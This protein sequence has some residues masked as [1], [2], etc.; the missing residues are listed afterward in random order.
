MF[1]RTNWTHDFP[2]S[3]ILVLGLWAQASLPGYLSRSLWNQLT[4]PLWS[5]FL[6]LCSAF[7]IYECECFACMYVCI[8]WVQVH[9]RNLAMSIAHKSFLLLARTTAFKL[10]L[11]FTFCDSGDWN[12]GLI[13][14][15]IPM[16]TCAIL[17]CSPASAYFFVWQRDLSH[18]LNSLFAMAAGNLSGCSTGFFSLLFVCL[19]IRS[20][21]CSFLPSSLPFSLPPFLP[22]SLSYLYF[23][24][25]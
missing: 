23:L 3:L 5:C 20:F 6:F 7:Y 16:W 1:S 15:C 13:F 12:K 2:S 11:C 19:F 24:L 8:P 4:S 18:A 10:F 21:I 17:S 22:L 25:Y 9:T 14:L